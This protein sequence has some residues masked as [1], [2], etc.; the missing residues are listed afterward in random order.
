MPDF[1]TSVLIRSTIGTSEPRYR[2]ASDILGNVTD[3]TLHI[4]WARS[5]DDVQELLDADRRVFN[6]TAPYGQGAKNY[7]AH[8]RFQGFAFRTLWSLKPQ[9]I[10]ACD[11]DTFIPSLIYRIFRPVKIIFDQ[12]DPLS[13][14]VSKKFVRKYLDYFENT[15]A[16]KADIRITANVRRMPLHQAENWIEIKNLFQFDLARGNKRE[17]K[18]HLQFFYGG[19]LSHDRGLIDLINVLRDTKNWRIDIFGQGPEKDNLLKFVSNNVAIHGYLPHDEL[20]RQAQSA[21]LYG[22]LYDPTSRN[23]QLTASNKLFEAAQLGVPLLTSRGTYLGEIVQKFKLGWTVTYGDTKEITNALGE[24]AS[25]T[26]LQ[27][28]EMA[29]NLACF[30]QGEIQVQIANIQKLENRI[31]SMMKSDCK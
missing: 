8:L 30:F 5:W 12:F 10:Y 13:A 6:L 4:N 20:M 29:S 16:K 3:S 26:E 23:N 28:A 31:T 22:A 15:F 21:D 14:R 1:V 9:I 17:K 2:H 27:R 18:D 25:L 19:I 7:L 24:C 11:F